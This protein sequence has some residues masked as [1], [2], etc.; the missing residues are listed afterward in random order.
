MMDRAGGGSEGLRLLV[1]LRPRCF[2]AFPARW[3]AA[4]CPGDVPWRVCAVGLRLLDDTGHVMRDPAVRRAS[5]C[6]L[7][8]VSTVPLQQIVLGA[9]DAVERAAH[10]F[11]IAGAKRAYGRLRMHTRQR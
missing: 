9:F 11:L 7:P 3:N 10:L 1:P 8:P 6:G 2:D 4:S 5:L